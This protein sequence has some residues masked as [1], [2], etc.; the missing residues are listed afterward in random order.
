MMWGALK[1]APRMFQFWASKQVM[2][3]AGVSKNLAKYKSRQS[4][5]CPSCDRAIETCA[6]VLA[7][8]EEGRVKN[9]SNS[10]RLCSGWLVTKSRNA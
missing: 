1:E 4:K 5:M 9:L 2:D 7:Y 6:N 3:V 10:L 8:R